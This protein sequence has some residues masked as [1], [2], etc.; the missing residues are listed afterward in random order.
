[1]SSTSRRGRPD[2]CPV[3]VVALA[4]LV[5]TGCDASSPPA[6][7]PTRTSSRTT[8]TTATP[9]TG[10]VAPSTPSTTTR[11]RTAAT[12]RSTAS[13]PTSTRTDRA[14]AARI[15]AGQLP[16]FGRAWPWRRRAATAAAPAGA[17]AG[18]FCIH[19][20]LVSIGAI[21]QWQTTYDG[22]SGARATVVSGQFSDAE[23][24]MMGEQVLATWQATCQQY[25]SSHARS[26]ST[27]VT[28]PRVTDTVVGPGYSV[29]VAQ[30]SLGR[31]TG[32]GYVR[33]GDTI[34]YVILRTGG[35]DDNDPGGKS[36][37]EKA[38]AVAGDRLLVAR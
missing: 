26:T 1:M 38:V 32:E 10:A 15:S 18:G 7:L 12:S 27:K 33:D 4:I 24:A 13:P 14:K 5:L 16:G 36:P 35:R 34:T 3:T 6:P 28:A 30:S 11:A 31:F 2:I 17:P 22:A 20:S 29:L 19:T 25:W 37:E 23:T 8:T 9:S 21:D